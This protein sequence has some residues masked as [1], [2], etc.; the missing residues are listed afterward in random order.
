M[1]TILIILKALPALKAL[2]DKFFAL[3][4]QAEWA[5][6]DK[7]IQKG[8]RKAID[9]HDQRELEKS[10]GSPTAG[11]PSGVPNSSFHDSLPL[12]NQD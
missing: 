5:S 9:E 2:V 7:D 4:A 6:F 11:L 12:S 10:I 8:I 1:E 3:Y